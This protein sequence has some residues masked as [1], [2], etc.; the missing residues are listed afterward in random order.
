MPK[1]Q[2]LDLNNLKVQSFV[3]SM[4][5]KEEQKVRG[6]ADSCAECGY[7]TCGPC[8]TRWCSDMNY[9]IPGT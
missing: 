7:Q 6:G 4:D 2:K 1:K 3:T 5:K 8:W 9:C